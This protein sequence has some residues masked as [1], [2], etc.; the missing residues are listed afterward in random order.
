MALKDLKSD[1][2]KF[3]RPLEKPLIEKPRV[4]VPKSSNQTPLSQFVDTT[5]TAPKSNLTTPK[6]GVTPN[7]FD[8]SSNFLG[9]TTQKQFDNSS[10]YLGETTPTKMS[11]KE[12]FLGQTEPNIV[13]QGDKFKGETETANITQGDRFKGETTPKGYSNAEKFKGETEPTEFKFVKQFLG[14]TD[15]KNTNLS[16]K[17]LGENTP[18]LVK[19]GDKFKGEVTPTIIEFDPKLEKQAKEI[20]YVDFFSNEDAKGFSPFQKSK[21]KSRFVG[22]DPTQT[23][24]DGNTSLYGVVKDAIYK[25]TLQA[26]NGLG[27]SYTNGVLKETY[28]KFNL[29]QDSPNFGFIKHP[30]I[31]TGIQTK[32]GEPFNYGIGGLSFIR[33]GA[34]TSTTRAAF[35]AVRIAEMLLTPRGLIWGLKQVGMQRTNTHGKTWTPINLLANVTSQ[36]LGLRWDRP[37]V[38][39]I[40]DETWKYGIKQNLVTVGDNTN[41]AAGFAARVTTGI[42]DLKS[43]YYRIQDPSRL[44][45]ILKQENGGPDSFYGI[46]KTFTTRTQNT[47]VDD[48]TARSQKYKV[49]G[50]NTNP[51][52]DS[53]NRTYST[54]IPVTDDEKKEFALAG[55]IKKTT[56]STYGETIPNSDTDKLNFGVADQ[57]QKHSPIPIDT[58]F[59]ERGLYKSDGLIVGSPDIADYQAITYA[60]IKDVADSRVNSTSPTD[61]RRMLPAERHLFDG[62]F[63]MKNQSLEGKYGIP[64][65]LKQSEKLKTK[66]Y[67]ADSVVFK[68]NSGADNV[69]SSVYNNPLQSDLVHL[70]FAYDTSSGTQNANKI[71]QFRATISGVTETFSPSWNGVK[72]PGRADKAYMYEEFERTLSLSFKVYA[73]SRSEMKNMWGKLQALGQLTLP[74]GSPYTGH[75]CWFR[76]GQLYGNGLKGVPTLLTSLTYTVPDDIP[77][78]TNYDGQ[79]AELP[80]GVDVAASLT[81]LPETRYK[82]SNKIYSHKI[83]G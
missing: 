7:K 83:F 40:G 22:V 51:L 59:D 31:L 65:T 76:L 11:L 75:I 20:T 55:K 36:H 5:P 58:K 25:T 1:L 39:P 3:R 34:V 29:K 67:G 24:F 37:G 47:F 60:Q 62:K 64:R 52:T 6:Q 49:F 35:D 26:D 14:E 30:L 4:D 57:T 41:K 16:P 21:S 43:L 12:R 44:G 70:F 74:T 54:D 48:E 53:P 28:N 66:L 27:K 50:E 79:L 8:N 42:T 32:K 13:Q 61:F 82:S 77:W 38:I 2:S 78:D 23:K 81:L 68:K 71:I 63:T 18:S 46:G 72:Y 73:T 17:F 33:G 80:M 56:P 69:N 9:E 10:N 15:T 19:Q 45:N